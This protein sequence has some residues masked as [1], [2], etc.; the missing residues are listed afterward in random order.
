MKEK[1]E[2]RY[3]HRRRQRS[4]N[5]TEETEGKAWV[6]WDQVR[7]AGLEYQNFKLIW[8]AVR[9]HQ[10]R[11]Y[12]GKTGFWGP[13][14]T[15]GKGFLFC[16]FFPHCHFFPYTITRTSSWLTGYWMIYQ[17]RYEF[18]LKLQHLKAAGGWLQNYMPHPSVPPTSKPLPSII[19]IFLFQATTWHPKF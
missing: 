15:L 10:P 3:E 1:C 2:Q 14:I 11:K 5:Y 17:F 8:Q 12:L 9:S 16:Q 13:Q 7:K 6:V 19:Y 4:V 18:T